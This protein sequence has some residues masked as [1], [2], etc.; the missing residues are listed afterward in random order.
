MSEFAE[1]FGSFRPTHPLLE[2]DATLEFV[3]S[4]PELTAESMESPSLGM[5]GFSG[6]GFLSQQPEFPPTYVDS[7][8]G[9]LRVECAAPPPPVS[10]R[11]ES[12]TR[13]RKKAASAVD[14]ASVNSSTPMP[15]S[16]GED[17]GKKKECSKKGKRGRCSEKDEE[18][19]KD[20]E[21]IHVRAKRGQ[22]TDSH[23]LAERVRR[24][25][26][27]EK[28]RC[29]Q[30][31]VPGCYKAMG[32]AVMLDEIINYVQSLQNQVEFL[33]MKLSAASAVYDF[34]LD[35]DAAAVMPQLLPR[36]VE[37][38]EA[39]EMARLMRGGEYEGCNSFHQPMPF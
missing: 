11:E 14:G 30:D 36:V 9:L 38:D 25:K 5:M 13:K 24:E 19:P 27:N 18:M 8:A 34:N 12:Q 29:L 3:N 23:S 17:K 16:G 26:I 2:M 10:I 1:D 28:M 4:F 37:A 7:L 33:S 39:Q 20:K 21:V 31:L 32:M 6:E 35:L 22:A 15:D